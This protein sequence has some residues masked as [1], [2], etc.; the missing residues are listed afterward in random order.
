MF[1]V[2]VVFSFFF[3]LNISHRSRLFSL[4]LLYFLDNYL[5][6]QV[7]TFLRSRGQT[8]LVILRF[9]AEKVLIEDISLGV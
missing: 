9:K 8:E 6:T 7:C 1:V 3:N 4:N 2:V 5:A